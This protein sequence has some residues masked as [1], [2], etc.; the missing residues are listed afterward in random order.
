MTVPCYL[1]TPVAA[2]EGQDEGDAQ[3]HHHVDIIKKWA[4]GVPLLLV[5]NTLSQ[6]L[7]LRQNVFV[8][9][10]NR[11]VKSD[12]EGIKT[13]RYLVLVVKTYK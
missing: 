9:L 4:H 7:L 11:F 5:T 3:E 8:Y 6:S 2:E 10:L 13:K 12:I 1:T